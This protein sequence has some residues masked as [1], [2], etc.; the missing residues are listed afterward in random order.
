[1]FNQF[2]ED[3]FT[4]TAFELLCVPAEKHGFAPVG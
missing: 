3:V 2:E 4:A 1:V